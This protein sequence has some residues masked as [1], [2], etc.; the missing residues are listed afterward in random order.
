MTSAGSSPVIHFGSTGEIS[1]CSTHAENSFF[2]LCKT[3][4]YVSSM[5][6]LL[7]SALCLPLMVFWSHAP[8]R[9]TSS[10]LRAPART[11]Y[12]HRARRRPRAPIGHAPT[13]HYPLSAHTALTHAPA[14]SFLL[15]TPSFLLAPCS[16]IHASPL[17]RHRHSRA[18]P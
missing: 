6:Y 1:P 12:C 3:F 9:P 5:I 16:F 2:G 11:P 10:R 17:R 4:T 15:P 14:F 8:Q 18:R 13:T 7:P